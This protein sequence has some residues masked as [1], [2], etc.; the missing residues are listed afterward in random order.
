MNKKKSFKKVIPWLPFSVLAFYIFIMILW[1][2]AVIPSPEAI[3]SFLEMVIEKIGILG[4]FLVAFLEGLVFIGHQFPG[5]SILIIS[6]IIPNLTL[7]LLASIAAAI[8]LAFTLS[9]IVNYYAGSIFSSRMKNKPK[10]ERT[11]PK[12]LFLSIVHPVFLSIYFFQRGI[13]K[14]G[15]RQVMYVPILVFPYILLFAL[16]IY[17]FSDFI[18]EKLL[19]EELFF[20]FIFIGWFI[21]ELILRNKKEIK[22]FLKKAKYSLI[23]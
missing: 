4:I 16:I 13:E 3:V 2:Y 19:K 6:L 8:T 5:S 17:F 23:K 10:K 20:L 9:S 15:I 7:S 14:K 18:R 11:T 21:F 1:D 22:I 12:T